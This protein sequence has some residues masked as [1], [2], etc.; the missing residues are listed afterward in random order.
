MI[1]FTGKPED[2]GPTLS[3]GV[4]GGPKRVLSANQIPQDRAYHLYKIGRVDVRR[5]MIVWGHGPQSLGGRLDLPGMGEGQGPGANQ[6][7]AYISLKVDGSSYVR[8][9]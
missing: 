8:G 2:H 9:Y 3:M 4:T 1:T 7:D 6:W 5:Q